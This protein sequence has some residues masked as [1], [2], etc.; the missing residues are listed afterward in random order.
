MLANMP[1]AYHDHH[2]CIHGYPMHVTDPT[3]ITSLQC[4]AHGSCETV[5][6]KYTL[7]DKTLTTASAPIVNP[8]P[9]YWPWP[10]LYVCIWNW[11][12]QL[13]GH[14]HLAPAAKCE[15]TRSGQYCQ[16]PWSL[17]AGPG[18]TTENHNRFCNHC[19]MFIDLPKDHIVVDTMDLTIRADEISGPMNTDLPHAPALELGSACASVPPPTAKH[20]SYYS[21]LMKSGRDDCFF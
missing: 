13:H 1:V 5:S 6:K 12:L 15:H 2:A 19:R 21:Q 20:L 4:Q 11:H 10:C 7:T 9:W 3:P 14:L 8:S 16:L 17:T 18:V